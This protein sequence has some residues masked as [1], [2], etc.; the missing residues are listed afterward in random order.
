M[1]RFKGILKTSLASLIPFVLDWKVERTYLHEVQIK[2]V[3]L[4]EEPNLTPEVQVDTKMQTKTWSSHPFH[5]ASDFQGLVKLQIKE[6]S[7]NLWLL[8]TQETA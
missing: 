3:T 6:K 4:M 7:R 5:W 8:M 1:S 2:D